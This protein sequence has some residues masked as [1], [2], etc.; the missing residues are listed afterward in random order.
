MIRDP[1]IASTTN[2]TGFG[3][4]IIVDDIPMTNNSTL[5][6]GTHG[7]YVGTNNGIDLREIPADN[8]ESV[9]IIR[10]IAP[11]NHGDYIGGLI[12]V[13]TKVSAKPTHRIKAK[14]NPDT[15]EVNLGG[16]FALGKT[17]V[18]YNINWGLSEKDIRKDYDNT[19]RLAT[20]LSLSNKLFDNKMDMKNQ[21]KYST[22]FE[23]VLQNPEDPDAQESINKGYRFIYGNKFDYSF[24]ALSKLSSNIFINYR[25]V[26]TIRQR[27]QMA[28]NRVTSTL[29][30]EGTM[31]GIKQYGPYIYRYTTIGDEISIGQRLNYERQF[32]TGSYL[33]KLLIGNEFQFDDNF[34]KGQT[35]DMLSPPALGKRPR[36]YDEVPGTLQ[37]SIYVTDQITGRLWKEFTLNFGLR[38]ERYNTGKISK[39]KFFEAKNGIFLNPRINLAYFLSKDTQLRLGFGSSSKSPSLSYIYPDLKYYDVLD[40]VPLNDSL[41]I[42]DSLIS[43][44]II[45]MSNPNLK[46]YKEN[47][48]ELSIDHKIGD[49]G[50]SFTG[51]YSE[52]NNEPVRSYNPFVYY[53][54][55]RPNW[56]D[57]AGE[58]IADTLVDKYSI[59]K[60]SGWTKL[61]GVEFTLKTR[62]IKK[63]NMDFKFN[64]SYHHVK[65]GSD[66]RWWGA[67]KNDFTVPIYNK[68]SKWTQKAVLTY[69]VNYTSKPLGIWVSFT[70]QQVPHYQTKDLGYSDTLAVAYYSAGTDEIINIPESEQMNSEYERYRLV[71][72][73]IKY[74]AFV[75]PNKWLFNIRV[76]KSLFE[77]AEVSLYVNNF[78]DNRAFYEDHKSPGKYYMR[79]PEIFYGMEF[80]MLLDSILKQNHRLR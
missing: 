4:K 31:V 37:H 44:Y 41:V 35:F 52:R 75:Y 27:L 45:D 53:K 46:G 42:R 61:D 21:F 20:Q 3:T 74:K 25:R 30:E 79:N 23:E 72:D 60:N 36:P 6:P 24:D 71:R 28:D 73:Q 76:S 59:Q 62:K 56:P 58:S 66:L 26:N 12:T 51:F 10:G 16:S 38:F 77:G 40:I 55:N 57:P 39:F 47:K 32:F 78:L 2:T 50:L 13:K 33:H 49:F 65:T 15:K 29:F 54:Y 5:Q 64:A 70:A 22:L 69:H 19:Q 67:V 63:L 80:S 48:V 43:T 17:G 7:V 14:N 8:I 9:E 11:A 18:N 68:A 1:R 34:G